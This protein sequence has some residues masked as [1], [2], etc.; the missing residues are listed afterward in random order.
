MTLRRPSSDR[1]SP[2]SPL[3]CPPRQP[4][5]S[6]QTVPALCLSSLAALT[7]WTSPSLAQTI[8][9]DTTL[10]QPTIVQQ[11]GSPRLWTITGGTPNQT[12]DLLFHSFLFFTLGTD[13]TVLFNNSPQVD[14]IFARVTGTVASSL[15]GTLRT[16]NP[17]N[18]FLLNPNGITMNSRTRLD[19]GG[20]F[21]ASTGDRLIFADGSYFSARSPN[22]APL[23]VVNPPTALWMG[24]NPGPITIGGVTHGLRYNSDFSINR[25]FR[26][27][28]VAVTPGQ[29]MGLI[30]NQVNLNG[31]NLTAT[32]GTIEIASLASGT[33]QLTTP[34]A[35][36]PW[37]F[38]YDEANSLFSPISLNTSTA[39]EVSGPGGG[40][41]SL[42]GSQITLDNG[43]VLLADTLG[44][45]TGGLLRVRGTES[46]TVT[47]TRNG[48]TSG[49]FAAVNPGAS[50][51][52][53]TLE[54]I[55][56]F[57]RTAN[58]AIIGVDTFG[59]GNAGTFRVRGGIVEVDKADWS[60]QSFGTSTG[61]GGEIDLGIETLRVLNGGQI[62][63]QSLGQGSAGRVFIDAKDSVLIQGERLTTRGNVL[64]SVITAFQS[65]G[66]RGAGEVEIKTGS[67]ILQDGGRISMTSRSTDSSLGQGSLVITARDFV[68]VTGTSSN[69]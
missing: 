42:Q 22:P 69:G 18:L 66:S 4:Q 59:S 56:P 61:R 44:S 2:R 13:E 21:F 67:L 3:P 20:S 14:H 11:S 25:Q 9:A 10:Q 23:L 27:T 37:R 49:L 29:F 60:V 35:G 36:S 62:L 63:A 19:I 57:F 6:R 15:P 54:V 64:N 28:G 8:R 12:G 43:S 34:T 7:A 41:L 38:S 16:S 30:G 24:N 55:T 58:G 31:A 51:S 26:S 39:V 1:R 17:A 52:G 33:V 53:G 65:E 45:Q 68:E 50:G 40:N 46:V 32:Q 5:L 47:G 48:F